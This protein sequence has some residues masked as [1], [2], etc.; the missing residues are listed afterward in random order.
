MLAK[1][2][3]RAGRLTEAIAAATDEVRAHPGDVAKRGFLCELLCFLGDLERADRQ[4]DATASQLEP[5]HTMGVSLLRH[6]LR[7][8]QARRHFFADGRVPEFLEA[9]SA[10]LRLRLEAS[11]FLREGKP[12]EAARIL[13]KAEAERP[14]IAGTSDGTAFDDLRD[15]DDLTATFFEVLTSNGKYYWVPMERVDSIEFHAPEF[16]RDLLWRRAHLVVR[17]GPDG[18]VY[19][20]ALYHGSHLHE[21]ER[22]RL[23]RATDWPGGEAAPVRGVGQRILLVG[24]QDVPI[25]EIKTIEIRRGDSA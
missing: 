15:L 14:P 16:P 18:E 4:L 1:D 24:D 23:G 19:V 13:E 7:A 21:D 11:I 10:D 22:I 17:G 2:H 12:D 25:L 3:F 6:L 8:E 5:R 20:A 9:P